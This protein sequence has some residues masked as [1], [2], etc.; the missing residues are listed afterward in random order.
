MENVFHNFTYP[1]ARESVQGTDTGYNGIE[2]TDW[3]YYYEDGWYYIRWGGGCNDNVA[4]VKKW[5]IKQN[6]HYF[7]TIDLVDAV[8]RNLDWPYNTIQVDATLI[9]KD[10][11]RLWTIYTSKVVFDR[12]AEERDS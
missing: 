3:N 12:I 8:T 1:D 4:V 11:R 6:G 7:V 5:E 10:D 9:Q 2:Y